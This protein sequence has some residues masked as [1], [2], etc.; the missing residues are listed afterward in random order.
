MKYYRCATCK[1]NCDSEQAFKVCDLCHN[2]NMYMSRRVDVSKF[3][4]AS[5][6]NT[7]QA[8]KMSNEIERILGDQVKISNEVVKRG[9]SLINQTFGIKVPREL[10]EKCRP[11][12]EKVIF[13]NP[14]TIVIWS[15]GT[16]T[17]VKCQDGG[18]DPEKGLAMA[19]SKK[20]LGNK[21]NYYE[22]FKKWL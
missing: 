11:R 12:I 9:E 8:I 1:Y 6:I 14:A 4:P 16:K 20:F 17:V 15:D 7:E 3:L 18:F 13:N 19:I 22:E 5:Q 2:E 10:I 21:G